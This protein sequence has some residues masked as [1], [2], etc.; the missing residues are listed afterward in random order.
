MIRFPWQK[1]K[2]E[3]IPKL[4]ETVNEVYDKLKAMSQN[5]STNHVFGTG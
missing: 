1:S 3:L 4:L 5:A 2:E